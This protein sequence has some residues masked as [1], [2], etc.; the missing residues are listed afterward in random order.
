[1]TRL[2]TTTMSVPARARRRTPAPARQAVFPVRAT[3]GHP[4]AKQATR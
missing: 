1:M 3:R 2:L 4:D